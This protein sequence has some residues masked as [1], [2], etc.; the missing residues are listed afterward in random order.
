MKTILIPTDFSATAKNSA[1]YAAHLGK[2][3]GVKRIILYNAYSIPLATEMSWAILQTE[4]LKKASED[5]LADFRPMVQSFAGEGIVVETR[6]DFGFLAERIG[7]VAAEEKADLIVMGITGGGRLEEVLIGSNTMH[8]IH[9]TDTPVIIVP[10]DCIWQPIHKIGWACDYK[11]VIK[12]TPVEGIKKMVGDMGAQ[13]VIMHN[14]VDPKAFDPELF[15]N[16]VV[17]GELFEH[18]HPEFV[19][20][21]KEVL[22][23][24]IDEFVSGQGIQM[25]LVIPRKHSW[26]ESIFKPSHTKALAFHGHIPLLCIKALK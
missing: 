14:D 15:H 25:L 1:I 7:E 20:S 24:A 22:T 12:T 26:I 4:E 8:V 17:V 13:L 9:H 18:L 6:S 10:P 11:N 16:N 3:L 19:H 23:E 5:N 21:N 2:V